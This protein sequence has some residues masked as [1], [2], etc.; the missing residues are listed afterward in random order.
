MTRSIKPS[1]PAHYSHI[2]IFESVH[3]QAP[4]L[5][6][7]WSCIC[8]YRNKLLPRQ[9]LNPLHSAYTITAH[10]TIIN[11]EHTCAPHNILCTRRNYTIKRTF[12]AATLTVAFFFA[13]AFSLAALYQKEVTDSRIHPR[14]KEELF[15]YL[16]ACSLCAFLTSGFWFLFCRMD[17]KVAPWIARLNFTFPLRVLF[18]VLFFEP[19]SCV[20]FL[21]FLLW[22]IVH[23]VFQGLRCMKWDFS[24]LPLEKLS[25]YTSSVHNCIQ[26]RLRNQTP[27]ISRLKSCIIIHGCATIDNKYPTSGLEAKSRAPIL[28]TVK[29]AKTPHCCFF[30]PKREARSLYS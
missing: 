4:S 21:C 17:S 18:F 26:R 7:P 19:S 11:L 13:A 10:M 6:K 24:D 12:P 30:T 28:S 2:V 1:P 20:H 23:R 16:M 5:L 8:W 27:T 22:R 25:T 9:Q 14:N 3:M 15:P 29:Y